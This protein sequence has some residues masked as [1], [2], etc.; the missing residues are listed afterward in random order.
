MATIDLINVTIVLSFPKCH[1]VEIIRC[2]TFSDWLFSFDNVHLKLLYMFSWLDSSCLSLLNNVLLSGCA[3]VCLL[4]HLLKDIQVLALM[5][6]A[7]V[8]MHVQVFVWSVL[9][10]YLFLLVISNN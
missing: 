10:I 3:R 8:N 6:R 5:N 9:F 2:E 4:V 1:I 7:A